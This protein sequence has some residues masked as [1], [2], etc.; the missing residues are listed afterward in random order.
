M[1][2][3]IEA[4]AAA[5]K[6]FIG[7]LDESAEDEGRDEPADDVE[8]LTIAVRDADTGH[9]KAEG[10]DEAASERLRVLE[11]KMPRYWCWKPV[12]SGTSRT[13]KLSLRR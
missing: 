3:G 4:G 2:L 12:P 7:G 5:L 8:A 11:A 9:A 1:L 10:V 6:L 13:R